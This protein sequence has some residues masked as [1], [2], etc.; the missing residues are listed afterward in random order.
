VGPDRQTYPL[1]GQ[2]PDKFA[3][4]RIALI[5]EAAHVFP[6]I[7]AQGLNLGLR[8]VEDLVSAA[9]N[10]PIDAGS[11]VV[12][13]QYDRTR[14]PDI[15]ARIGAVHAL[16]RSLISGMLPAQFARAFGLAALDSSAPL[17]SLF[18][19]EGMRPGTGFGSI[20]DSIKQ[21]VGKSHT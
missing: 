9:V 4:N 3:T 11:S 20:F 8:D 12:T 1:S 10:N 14:R 19:R 18:M 5:G 6:P 21:T 17:R 15:M 16:N 13:D 7:G 2:Y